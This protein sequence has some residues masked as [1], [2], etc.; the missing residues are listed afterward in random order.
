M[1]FFLHFFCRPLLTRAR[2]ST[3]AV[4]GGGG[5]AGRACARRQVVSSLAF[6][7]QKYTY[8]QEPVLYA[9]VVAALGVLARGGKYSVYLLYW[10]TSTHTDAEARWHGSVVVKALN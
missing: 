9:E 3:S 2:S 7:V 10:Y 8:W 1:I 5:S 4:C 6:P